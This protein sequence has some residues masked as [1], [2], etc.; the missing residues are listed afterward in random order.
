MHWVSLWNMNGLHAI[1]GF[2]ELRCHAWH[3]VT[4]VT[5]FPRSAVL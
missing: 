4:D 3:I 1:V 2:R 5:P